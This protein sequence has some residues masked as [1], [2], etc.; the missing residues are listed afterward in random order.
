[1]H[2]YYVQEGHK[3]V[4]VL[5]YFGAVTIPAMVTRILPQRSDA[6][7]NKIYYEFVEFNQLSGINYLWFD[8]EGCF[9]RLQAAVG[10]GPEEGWTQEERQDF[11][12]FYLRFSAAYGA[13]GS[14]S[15]EDAML[16]MLEVCG[17]SELKDCLEGELRSRWTAIREELDL[18]EEADQEN[19]VKKAFQMLM[20]PIKAMTQP[21]MAMLSREEDAP[22]GEEGQ[23]E[24]EEPP[25]PED[26]QPAP[27][28]GEAGNPEPGAEAEPGQRTHSGEEGGA[29]H[30]DTGDL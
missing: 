1:M 16:L 19:S 23:A 13:K 14:I 2:Y 10:K 29:G 6:L 28:T 27:L 4:S 21:V 9:A 8:R 20:Q 24:G 5:R 15:L 18:P 12:S 22:A 3:R 30:A 26:V 17:Y 11:F 7:E 25:Q